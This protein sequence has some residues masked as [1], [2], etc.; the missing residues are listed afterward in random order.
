MFLKKFINHLNTFFFTILQPDTEFSKLCTMKC[1][2]W[3][4]RISSDRRSNNDDCVSFIVEKVT[5]NPNGVHEKRNKKPNPIFKES[6]SIIPIVRTATLYS[7]GGSKSG[8]IPNIGR[9]SSS[10]AGSLLRERPRRP[11]RFSES[12]A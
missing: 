10:F 7:S 11:H 1:L 5:V 8:S 3:D 2:S 6:Q 9:S 4:P 12:A